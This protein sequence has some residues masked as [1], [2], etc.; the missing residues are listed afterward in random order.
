MM[1]S[2]LLGRP[3]EEMDTPVLVIDLDKLE[4]NIKRCREL[5]ADAGLT[6]RPHAKT[7]KSPIIAQMQIAAGATGVCCA[8]LAEA[9][10][11]AAG[12]VPDI[13]ITTEVVGRL[14]I[15]RLMSVARTMQAG[16]RRI[17]VVVDDSQN[18]SDLSQAAE[19]SGID[20]PVI[21]DVDVGMARTGAPAGEAA[22]G[23]A[24]Q[25]QNSP[26]L[27]FT[28]FQGYQGAIQM[29]EK[30]SEREDLARAALDPL[31]ETADL[32]R[33]QGLEFEVLT[34]GGT[35]TAVIDTA[36]GGLTE[37]QPG[38]YIFMDTRYSAIDWTDRGEKPPFENALS[39]HGTVV[40]RPLPE[41]AT[42]DVGM[43]AASN[44]GGPAMP[45]GLPGTTFRKAGDEHGVLVFEDGDC[46]LRVGD[47]V[48][49]YP[50]H[51]DTTINLYDHYVC[52]RNGIVEAVWE[53]AARGKVQ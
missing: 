11:M 52:V 5:V 41:R 22:V 2:V 38:S 15:R 32:A 13:L 36:L 1:E 34:G 50:S 39:V 16:G 21:V 25:V 24:A 33:K 31:L 48:E 46:P 51:C 3:I 40:S 17:A 6:Y 30:F 43:K 9:E 29:R 27:R 47:R 37:L 8:K 49:F 28:G 14:K 10:V 7:H 42:V 18:V 20:L 12:G 4:R 23:I 45:L 19:T 53:V 44:D 26:H 35:G